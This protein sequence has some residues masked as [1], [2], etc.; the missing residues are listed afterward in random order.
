VNDGAQ[1]ERAI[2][3]RDELEATESALTALSVHISRTFPPPA[4]LTIVVMDEQFNERATLRFSYE[5][6]E[7]GSVPRYL[8]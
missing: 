8:Q 4:N 7:A 2:H 5:A 1:E 6:P 3:A